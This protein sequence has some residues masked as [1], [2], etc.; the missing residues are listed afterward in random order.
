VA[1]IIGWDLILEYAVGNVAIAVSWSDYFLHL[2][3]GLT[4]IQLPLWLTTDTTTALT[5][6]ATMHADS[7]SEPSIRRLI[8]P[9]YLVIQL[10][11]TCPRLS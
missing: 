9:F 11:S 1:W 8:C 7:R 4:G 3:H 6:I 5:R 2:V 10:L